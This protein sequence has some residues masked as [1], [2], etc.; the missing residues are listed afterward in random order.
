[1]QRT[2]QITGSIAMASAK[3]NIYLVSHFGFPHVYNLSCLIFGR[4]SV[5]INYVIFLNLM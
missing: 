4:V 2:D 1:M 5:L 3:N